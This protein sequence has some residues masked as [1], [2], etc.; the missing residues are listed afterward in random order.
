VPATVQVLAGFQ[1][2]YSESETGCWSTLR[3]LGHCQVTFLLSYQGLNRLRCSFGSL[4]RDLIRIALLKRL[5]SV[6]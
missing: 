2:R 6:V 4:K 5:K 1:R 3:L